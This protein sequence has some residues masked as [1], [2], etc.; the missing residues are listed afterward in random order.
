MV[1]CSLMVDQDLLKVGVRKMRAIF[2][3]STVERLGRFNGNL[4]GLKDIMIGQS[5]PEKVTQLDG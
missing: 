1:C 2:P 4:I 3:S 5:A